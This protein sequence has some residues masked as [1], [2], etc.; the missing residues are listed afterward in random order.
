MY[1]LISLSTHLRAYKV[2]CFRSRGLMSMCTIVEN[3]FLY[4][5]NKLFT[6]YLNIGIVF[7]IDS[8]YTFQIY[9]N[10]KYFDSHVYLH[11]L[12][13]TTTTLHA[14]TRLNR[15]SKKRKKIYKFK[16]F[17]GFLYIVK[18]STVTLGFTYPHSNTSCLPYP[19]TPNFKRFLYR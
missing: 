10:L 8:I 18:T 14:F 1:I 16:I 5:N 9:F 17:Y 13:V 11:I 12:K 3:F 2:F 15:I 6:L 19:L 4:T 7:I